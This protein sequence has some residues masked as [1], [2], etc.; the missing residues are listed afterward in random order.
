MSTPLRSGPLAP[1]KS[2]AQLLDMCFLEMR[3]AVLETA[4]AMDRIERAA[5]GTDVAGDPRLRK[6]AEACRILREAQ[7]NRAE[8]VQVL[9]SDPA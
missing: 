2:A 7:G 1:R 8:Q 6:L 9:F 4:A 5:G 3:S